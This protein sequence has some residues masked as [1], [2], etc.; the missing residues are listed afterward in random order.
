MS[1][2]LDVR[3]S[4]KWL[5]VGVEGERTQSV[6]YSHHTQKKRKGLSSDEREEKTTISY[7]SYGINSRKGDGAVVIDGGKIY[8]ILPKLIEFLFISSF[9]F[10][11]VGFF[12][13]LI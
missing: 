12:F 9:S 8:F 4:E 7:F 11:F 13:F 6:Q 3:F 10:F 2:P 1:C 5:H